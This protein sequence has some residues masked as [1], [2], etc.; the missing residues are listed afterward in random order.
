MGAPKRIGYIAAPRIWGN[1]NLGANH[2]LAAPGGIIGAFNTMGNVFFVDWFNGSNAYDGTLPEREGTTLSG[3][4]KT[5][6]YALTQCV[7]DHDDYIIVVDQWA[8]PTVAVN[9][10]RVHIIGL[11]S[12]PSRLYPVW[13]S[14]DNDAAILTISSPCNLCEIAGLDIGGGVGHAGIENVAG[15]PM[16]VYIHHCIF[17]SPWIGGNDPQDGIRIGANATA[18]RV[19]ACKF[20]GTSIN[21]QGAITRDGIRLAAAANSY[22]G[23][24]CD[25]IFQGIPDV[26]IDILTHGEALAI[27][28]N[29]FAIE[30][31]AN[32]E[33]ITLGAAVVG[34]MLDDNH[35]INGNAQADYGFTPYRDLNGGN[36]HWGRNYRGNAVI[37]PVT[38]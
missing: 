1:L 25:N 16:G 19:E 31:L 34:V 33:A 13:Y 3:P 10:T 9:V 27:K 22:G 35:A 6:A 23:D 26:A 17:G 14:P 36:N 15:T 2:W 20:L 29:E 5:V 21:A 11:S 7:D 4:F 18:L 24:I 37:E 30:D 12:N 28:R 32:G 38:V 8:E